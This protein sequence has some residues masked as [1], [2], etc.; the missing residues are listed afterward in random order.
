MKAQTKLVV[1]GLLT[2]IAYIFHSNK[3]WF[4]S[5]EVADSIYGTLAW[6]GF[7][8]AFWAWEKIDTEKNV[9]KLFATMAWGCLVL[10]VILTVIN[11]I[12][13]FDPEVNSNGFGSVY[14]F[15][16]CCVYFCLAAYL[17]LNSS[18]KTTKKTA[19]LS[20]DQSVHNMD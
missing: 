10:V 17:I 11:M 7:I 14:I 4:Y 6:F 15:F 5:L 9:Y 20:V 12:C 13:I 1:S 3:E 18:K 8:M 16:S 19:E 2:F